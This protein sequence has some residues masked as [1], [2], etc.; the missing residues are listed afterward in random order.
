MHPK[1]NILIT[2]YS[3][4]LSDVTRSHLQCSK[5]NEQHNTIV[6][7]LVSSGVG[8]SPV[9]N[10]IELV[11]NHMSFQQNQGILSCVYL[12]ICVLLFF[13]PWS[14]HFFQHQK[15]FLILKYKFF[16]VIHTY[17]KIHACIGFYT[18]TSCYQ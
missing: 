9:T 4:F 11:G 14:C 1:E 8:G 5:Y 18:V 13:L 7:Y 6:K 12:F 3:K 2:L 10:L 15:H 17:T 16:N